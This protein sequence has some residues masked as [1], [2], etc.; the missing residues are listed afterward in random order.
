[1]QL[2]SATDN[3]QNTRS[4]SLWELLHLDHL[5]EEAIHVVR[6]INKYSDLFRLL[7]EMFGYIDVIA[8]TTELNHSV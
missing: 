5:K 1:M 4:R 2:M 7:D 8:F 6:I 3:I